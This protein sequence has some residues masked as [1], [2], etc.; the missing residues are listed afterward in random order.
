VKDKLQNMRKEA[1][2]AWLS[3][4][5]LISLIGLRRNTNC[6]RFWSMSGI[7]PPDY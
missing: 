1:P 3:Y 4:H 7:W 6:R 5:P 2:V